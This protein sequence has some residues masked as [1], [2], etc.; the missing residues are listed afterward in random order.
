MSRLF[1]LFIIIF[2]GL[3]GVSQQL[4]FHWAKQIGGA[5]AICRP[6]SIT[7]DA[8]G[9]I[10][11]VGLFNGT[12]DFD[13][14]Q[15]T[16]YLSSNNNFNIFIS[17]IDPYGNLLWAIKTGDTE[18][19]SST[20]IAVDATGNV[21]ATGIFEGNVDF[22]PGPGIF[23]ITS[24]GKSD[25]F[26]SKYNSS[27]LFIWV[28]Q[29][30]GDSSDIVKSISID[31]NDNICLAG[32]FKGSSDFDPGVTTFSLTS[33]YNRNIFISKVNSSGDFIWAKQLSSTNDQS[34]NAIS[35][36]ITGNIYLAGSFNGIIDFDPGPLTYSLTSYNEIGAYTLKIDAA[37]NFVW[38]KII[39]TS[40]HS[41]VYCNDIK[42]DPIGNVYTT[43]SFQ[44]N[45]DF[46]PG[47]GINTMTSS[48]SHDIYVSKLDASGN[49]IWAKKMGGLFYEF[50]RAIDNDE[51]G[52]I[53]ITGYFTTAVDFD[54]GPGTFY[55]NTSGYGADDFFICK[56]NTYG[57]LSWA[58]QVGGSSQNHAYAIARDRFG[59]IYTSGEFQATSDF[60][61]DAGILYLSAMGNYDGF[62]HKIGE[63][64][65]GIE[66]YNYKLEGLVYP[67]PTT[68][69]LQ[70][71]IPNA[72][73]N[74]LINIF[75]LMGQTVYQSK[76]SSDS[77]LL[78]DISSQKAGL[79]IVEIVTK[80][81]SY[82]TKIIKN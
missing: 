30:G 38:A 20:D 44:G 13:P 23:N 2:L 18:S 21:Y 49:F 36:D 66:D 3:K 75:D 78:V 1:V 25:I 51:F 63:G 82:R 43:G 69:L 50:G 27:G 58:K 35:N 54:P 7:T 19:Y 9:N 46:D 52:N 65:V 56:I 80:N 6:N 71:T 40:L 34:V 64:V 61:V 39:N 72:F 31:L 10:Y 15:S 32:S 79:F 5:S 4:N 14:G 17:K 62:L 57:D 70:I 33:M 24:R 67:N 11:T 8:N 48:G 47:V 74:S 53:Y 12:V 77:P 28:K 22:D 60:N 73:D 16:Y 59:N 42:I 41:P 37:G 29:F 76:G 68:G 81:I 26:L 55:L 45:P